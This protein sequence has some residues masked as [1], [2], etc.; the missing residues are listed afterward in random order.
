MPIPVQKEKQGLE[1]GFQIIFF[2]SYSSSSTGHIYQQEHIG[3]RSK[4]YWL[5]EEKCPLDCMLEV[6][7]TTHDP[8]SKGTNLDTP[9]K[10]Y[11][12]V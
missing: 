7:L 12:W 5:L 4:E 6:D 8:S 1:I 10:D 3:L 9:Q 2:V 11:I